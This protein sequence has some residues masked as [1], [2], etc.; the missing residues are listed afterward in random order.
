MV[1]FAPGPFR[2]GGSGGGGGCQWLDAGP[3]AGCSSVR[4][5]R[6]FLGGGLAGDVKLFQ[7]ALGVFFVL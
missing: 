4:P 5:A 1:V 6:S 2:G 3:G 7:L